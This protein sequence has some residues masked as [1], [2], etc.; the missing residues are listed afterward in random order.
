MKLNLTTIIFQKEELTQ[1]GMVTVNV[2]VVTRD[3][4]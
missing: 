1:G 2:I 3:L 4:K